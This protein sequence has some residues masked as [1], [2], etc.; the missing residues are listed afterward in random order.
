MRTAGL[1]PRSVGRALA[2]L[3]LAIALFTPAA[4]GAAA[5][6]GTSDPS[7][8]V[9][10][11]FGNT[12]PQGDQGQNIMRQP[13]AVDLVGE[14]VYAGDR[15]SWHVQKFDS[16]HNWVDQW[17]EYGTGPGQ[18][19]AVGGIAHDSSGNVYVLD[20]DNNRV[21][22]FDSNN[23]FLAAWGGKGASGAGSAD[24]NINFKGGIVVDGSSTVY[25][26]DTYN[27]RVVAFD[28]NGNY[29]RQLGVTGVSGSDNS[30]FLYPQGLTVDSA[31]NL[32]VADDQNNRIQKFDS[33]GGYLATIGSSSNLNHPYDVGVDGAGFVYVADNLNHRIDKFSASGSFMKSWGGKGTAP[34]QLQTPRAI[35]VD[36]AG[37]NFV[38]DTNNERMQEFDANGA[39]V[40]SSGPNPWGLNGRDGGRLSGPEGLDVAGGKLVIAD[41]LEYW[42]QELNPTDGGFIAKFGGHGTGPGQFELPADVAVDAAGTTDVADT[43][44]GRV[45]QFDSSNTYIDE[46]TGFSLPAGV[47]TDAARNFYVADTG[48]NRVQKFSPSGT[49][50]RTWTSF[51]A[52]DAFS[53]PE[54]IA[55]S[56]TGQLYVADTGHNRVVEFD[57][58]GA[59]ARAWDVTGI[60]A[61]RPSGIAVDDAGSVY[62]A[63]PGNGDVQEYD[64]AGSVLRM[65]GQRGHRLGEFWTNGPTDVTTDAGGSVYVSDTYDN[66]IEKFVF[67]QAS[68][69]PANT[70][71]PTISG[72]AQEGNTL[73][74]DPGAWSGS[75]TGYAYQWRRCD[76]AGGS[77][78]DIANAT[79]TTYAL[80]SAD[81]S[82][83]IRVRVVAS[84]AAG[85]SSPVDSDPTSTIQAAPAGRIQGTVT[86][87]SKTRPPIAGAVVNCGGGRSATTDATGSYTIV[88]LPAGTYSCTASASGYR[89]KTQSVT[90]SSG[91][92]ATLS[93][94]LRK[95]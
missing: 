9:T 78:A 59:F 29:L 2:A 60:V 94:S 77:C 66:R 1:L 21:E 26:S 86:Q 61:S 63:D 73:T 89:A 39:L 69:P 51:G 58:S 91:Q 48:N 37:D 50:L 8:S 13:Q 22:K 16:S 38:A 53:S 54:D 81:V 36:S 95:A 80:T 46:T 71:P 3:L 49:L 33:G 11:A 88:N 64:A 35:A 90:L 27:H 32:Y 28:T 12:S 45:Q 72:V 62:V 5:C 42:T 67:A 6:P 44:N 84:N 10:A 20:I 30:H 31:H 47:A 93:F 7:C 41:T 43:N 75:P 92:T 85:P 17:G 24:F 76:T 25:V 52:S 82:H 18:L 74:A 87:Q 57:A 4:A 34:G 40:T 68:Q 79:A 56:P 14:R 70:S 83:T 19:T 15:W 65:W 23:N 55:V